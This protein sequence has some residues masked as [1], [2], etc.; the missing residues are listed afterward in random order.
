MLFVYSWRILKCVCVCFILQRISIVVYE[1]V[2]AVFQA[3]TSQ[4]FPSSSY[5]IICKLICTFLGGMG[6]YTSN[7][8]SII[9]GYAPLLLLALYYNSQPSISG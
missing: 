7:M 9:S 1:T 5:N 6:W 8:Q 4:P 3:Y 2:V